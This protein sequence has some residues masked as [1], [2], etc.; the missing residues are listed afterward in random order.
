M[1]ETVCL[2]LSKLETLMQIKCVYHIKYR[3]HSPIGDKY[4]GMFVVSF[5]NWAVEMIVSL[6]RT[7]KRQL[8]SEL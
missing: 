3:V 4:Q 5:F 7:K 2:F 8:P 1:T 6:G